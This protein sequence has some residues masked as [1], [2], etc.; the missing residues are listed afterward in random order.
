MT[1]SHTWYIS[2]RQATKLAIRYQVEG[3]TW[4]THGRTRLMPPSKK[5]RAKKTLSTVSSHLIIVH[6]IFTFIGKH[7]HTNTQ[8]V[9]FTFKVGNLDDDTWLIETFSLI[10]SNHISFYKID[11]N[12]TPIMWR[13]NTKTHT[14]IDMN[15]V[16]VH[17]IVS[18]HSINIKIIIYLNGWTSKS[19]WFFLLFAHS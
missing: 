2:K 15:E 16:I 3:C 11:R 12:V 17:Q 4:P 9:W 8:M 14:L 5:W 7:T 19:I 10:A 18:Y 13:H 6:L 1:N